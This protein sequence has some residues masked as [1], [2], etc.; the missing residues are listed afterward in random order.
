[1]HK[2]NLFH[3]F[4]FFKD[5]DALLLYELEYSEK[6]AQTGCILNVRSFYDL[7]PAPN[8]NEDSDDEYYILLARKSSLVRLE[9]VMNRRVWTYL[10]SNIF[11]FSVLVPNRHSGYC[12]RCKKISFSCHPNSLDSVKVSVFRVFI[13]RI[14]P[15][16]N[17]ECGIMRTRKT[18][19]T[20]TIYAKI[21]SLEKIVHHQ[22]TYI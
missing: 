22:S 4:N 18:P 1:M 9:Q 10:Y 2:I 16:A 11:L 14:F 20:D 21:V 6:Y 19:N 12:H 15:H 17:S 7:V 5:G 8:L 3:S 13:V